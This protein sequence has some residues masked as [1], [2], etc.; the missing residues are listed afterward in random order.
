LDQKQG[1]TISTFVE[2]SCSCRPVSTH[3]VFPDKVQL[4][5]K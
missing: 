2:R 5:L 1:N 3:S 4:N